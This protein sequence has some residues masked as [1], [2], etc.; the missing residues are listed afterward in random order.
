[1]SKRQG[2]NAAPDKKER[3][4][5][6]VQI[7]RQLSRWAKIIAAHEEISIGEVLNP[8]LQDALADR[9]QRVLSQLGEAPAS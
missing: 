9:F 6:S 4:T 2:K 8:M 3:P 5:A 1:M 7:D